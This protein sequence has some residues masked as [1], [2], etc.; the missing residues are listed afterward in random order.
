M[1]GWDLTALPKWVALVV[2]IISCICSIVPLIHRKINYCGKRLLPLLERVDLLLNTP[3]P[4]AKIL[5][6]I[7]TMI[8]HS[9]LNAF[10]IRA[11]EIVLD[12]IHVIS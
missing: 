4:Y 6:R 7:R 2:A 10:Q 3:T 8:E 5:Y 1:Y 9:K 12:L 11:I